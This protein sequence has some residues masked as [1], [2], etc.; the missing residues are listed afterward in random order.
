MN[1]MHLLG[2]IGWMV[3]G[4]CLYYAGKKVAQYK[5]ASTHARQLE[6]KTSR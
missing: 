2:F 5:D 4:V 1:K 3:M 6:S